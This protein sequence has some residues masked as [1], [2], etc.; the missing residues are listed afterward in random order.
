MME[1]SAVV[2]AEKSSTLPPG[3]VYKKNQDA[4]K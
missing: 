4:L 1:S 2:E 3:G